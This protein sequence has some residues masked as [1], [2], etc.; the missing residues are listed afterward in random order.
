M[1]TDK[2]RS[3]R[4][5]EASAI[6]SIPFQFGINDSTGTKISF[7]NDNWEAIPTDKMSKDLGLLPHVSELLNRVSS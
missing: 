7:H 3:N 2:D 6:I 1:T 5:Y 4:K